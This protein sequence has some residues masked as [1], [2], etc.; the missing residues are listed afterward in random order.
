MN[1]SIFITAATFLFEMKNA[2]PLCVCSVAEINVYY[3]YYYLSIRMNILFHQC[4]IYKNNEHISAPRKFTRSQK[5][6]TLSHCYFD[7]NDNND[8]IDKWA[9]SC[10]QCRVECTYKDLETHK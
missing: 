9:Y 7:D 8:D 5:Y 4:I 2:L 3:Y 6:R 10:I 1:S